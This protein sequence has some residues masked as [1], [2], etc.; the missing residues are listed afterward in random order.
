ML[1]YKKSSGIKGIEKNF[2]LQQDPPHAAT[3]SCVRRRIAWGKFANCGQTCIAPDYI[4]CEPCIQGRVVECIRQTLLVRERLAAPLIRLSAAWASNSPILA[5]VRPLR[6][7]RHS[8]SR[9]LPRV[10]GQTLT[11]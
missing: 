9:L 11:L 10:T 1:H 5:V 4:L 8:L 2:A 3:S 6:W 7:M